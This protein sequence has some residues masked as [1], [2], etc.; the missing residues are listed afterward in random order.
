V[1]R[2]TI[3]NCGTQRYLVDFS[4]LGAG[5]A[6]NPFVLNG[7]PQSVLADFLILQIGGIDLNHP[8]C[9]PVQHARQIFS[10]PRNFIAQKNVK[11]VAICQLCYRVMPRGQG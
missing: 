3:I 6:G 7:V 10:L 1:T 2:E 4:T 8:Q 11:H 5:G 9:D